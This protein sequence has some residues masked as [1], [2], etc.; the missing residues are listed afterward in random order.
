MPVLQEKI[1]MMMIAVRRITVRGEK[2][3][4]EYH[5]I[6]T[7][8]TKKLKRM[9]KYVGFHHPPYVYIACQKPREQCCGSTLVSM[10]VWI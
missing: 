3:M 10:R 1:W 8:L 9:L 5:E 7:R 2:V 6:R 4:G